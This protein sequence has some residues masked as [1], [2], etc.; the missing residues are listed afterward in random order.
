VVEAI[1][2]TPAS[3]V[4]NADA[5]EKERVE[6]M[7]RHILLVTQRRLG[8]LNEMAI[9][10][11]FERYPLKH[12]AVPTLVV[13]AADGLYGTLDAARYTTEHIR[14]ARFVEYGTGGHLL[15]GHQQALIAEIIAFLSQHAF[16]PTPATSAQSASWTAMSRIAAEPVLTGA[17]SR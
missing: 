5:D 17:A 3:V 1:L 7:L 4:R 13:S 14:G 12:S 2:D 8:L 6:R 16:A 15:V 11:A 10:S 9:V